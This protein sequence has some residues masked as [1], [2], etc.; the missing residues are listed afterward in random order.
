MIIWQLGAVLALVGSSLCV[1]L[2]GVAWD[3]SGLNSQN[4]DDVIGSER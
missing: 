1:S 2:S 3:A 4:Y